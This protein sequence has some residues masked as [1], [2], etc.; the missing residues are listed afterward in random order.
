[1]YQ[2]RLNRVRLLFFS[3]NK[4]Q[5]INDGFDGNSASVDI[6]SNNL[7][8]IQG[9]TEFYAEMSSLEPSKTSTLAPLTSSALTLSSSTLALLTLPSFTSTSSTTR[10]KCEATCCTSDYLYVP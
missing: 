8:E 6:L 3:Q 4:K 5:R 1:V 7:N 9:E 2:C 10:L